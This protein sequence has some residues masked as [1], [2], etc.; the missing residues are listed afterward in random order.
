M[1]LLRLRTCH[2]ECPRIPIRRPSFERP[3]YAE[4]RCVPTYPRHICKKI[5]PLPTAQPVVLFDHLFELFLA[6]AGSAGLQRLLEQP[7]R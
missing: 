4:Q 7:R 3:V 6:E 5:A 2:C 1:P